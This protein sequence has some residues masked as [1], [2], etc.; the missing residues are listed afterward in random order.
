MRARVSVFFRKFSLHFRTLKRRKPSHTSD[1]LVID[2]HRVQN[3]RHFER[4]EKRGMQAFTYC[5]RIEKLE[6]ACR[7]NADTKCDHSC[8]KASQKDFAT[9]RHARTKEKSIDECP[10]YHFP[11]LSFFR[12]NSDLNVAYI[13]FFQHSSRDKCNFR[14]SR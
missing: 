9:G 10:K 12:D 2:A 7:Y 11:Q 14:F 8:S 4:I 1:T 3:H 13:F 6:C 5:E